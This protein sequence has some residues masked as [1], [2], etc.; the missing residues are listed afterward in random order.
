MTSRTLKM[1]VSGLGRMGTRHALNV[2]YNSPRAELVG[3][4]DPRPAAQQWAKTN[5]IGV[6]VYE[7]LE[8]CVRKSGAE[9]V[10]V[11]SHTGSHASNVYT[12]LDAG[13]VSRPRPSQGEVADGAGTARVVREAYLCG[14]ANFARSGASC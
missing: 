8:Q 6:P 11:S 7:T 1:A 3:V 4:C 5:L 9:A 10:L 14:S 2:L 13:K 12:A